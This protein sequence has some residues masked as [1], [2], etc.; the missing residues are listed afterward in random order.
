MAKRGLDNRRYIIVCM[1]LVLFIILFSFFIDSIFPL[2]DV[3]EIIPSTILLGDM[4]KDALYRD[5]DIPNGTVTIIEFSD[6][7]CPYCREAQTILKRA[8]EDYGD[9]VQIIFRHFPTGHTFSTAAAEASECA[10]DQGMFWPY[11]DRLFNS[12]ISSMQDFVD[13]AEDMGLDK[14]EFSDCLLTHK[15]LDIVNQDAK[16]GMSMN[17]PGTPTFIIGDEHI[18]G[19]PDYSRLEEIIDAQ[20]E[21]IDD[22]E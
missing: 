19:I 5:T 11:H 10:A 16:L 2:P 8:K 1:A 20:L 12:H 22:G 15:K 18:L 21:A 7:E 13:F 14:G 17:V 6:F 3:D 4:D 9:K